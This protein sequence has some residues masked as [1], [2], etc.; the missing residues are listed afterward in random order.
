MLYFF[1]FATGIEFLNHELRKLRDIV[2]TTRRLALPEREVLLPAGPESRGTLRPVEALFLPP[3]LYRRGRKPNQ[4]C[5]PCKFRSADSMRKRIPVVNSDYNTQNRLLSLR[6]ANPLSKHHADS[7][8]IMGFA[9]FLRVFHVLLLFL[10]ANFAGFSYF[11]L[12]FHRAD[13]AD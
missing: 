6:T 12:D 3:S 7:R 11:N 8:S 2:V 1:G 5:R 13:A 4:D 9:C 10:S